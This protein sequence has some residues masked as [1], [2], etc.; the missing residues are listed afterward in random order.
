MRNQLTNIVG[1]VLDMKLFK[2][3]KTNTL[4]CPLFAIETVSN[5]TVT[6]NLLE[7]DLFVVRQFRGSTGVS[8]P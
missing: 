5:G 8:F 2:N 1:I 3:Y 4:A 6:N 7:F